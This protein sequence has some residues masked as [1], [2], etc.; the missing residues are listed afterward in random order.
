MHYYHP[1]RMAYIR[2]R[3]LHQNRPPFWSPPPPACAVTVWAMT[4]RVFY[5]S[6]IVVWSRT[7]SRTSGELC[8]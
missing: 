4:T 3:V 1:H 5:Q 2:M 7:R 8:E 6:V